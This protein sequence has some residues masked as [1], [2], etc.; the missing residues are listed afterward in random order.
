MPNVE[1]SNFLLTV[2]TKDPLIVDLPPEVS[3]HG[4][5]ELVFKA[6]KDCLPCG[7]ISW[8]RSPWSGS[9]GAFFMAG[10]TEGVRMAQSLRLLSSWMFTS[11]LEVI[12][13]V[14]LAKRQDISNILCV[15]NFV[16]Q[17]DGTVYVMFFIWSWFFILP[18][19]QK[20]RG[21]RVYTS[22]SSFSIN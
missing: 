19:H 17:F 4:R 1:I 20:Q 14:A 22:R 15:K 9:W 5:V 13:L 21:Q 12:M 18:S 11:C 16:K 3:S 7:L 8:D 10:G 2:N 6:R